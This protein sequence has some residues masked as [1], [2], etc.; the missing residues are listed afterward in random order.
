MKMHHFKDKN[1]PGDICPSSKK[2]LNQI[3]G[4]FEVITETKN[5]KVFGST[6]F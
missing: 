3:F 2:D 1:C 5:K 4:G 6:K